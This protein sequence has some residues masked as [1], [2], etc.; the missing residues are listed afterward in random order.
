M[1]EEHDRSLAWRV[2]GPQGSGVDTAARLFGG[3]CVAGG[4]HVFGRREYYSNIM[5][6]HSYYDVRV[7]RRPMSC[8]RNQVEMLVTFDAETLAR[9]SVSTVPG[10]AIIYDEDAADEPLRRITFLDER[11]QEDL[12]AYLAASDLPPTTA[13]ALEDAR[14]RGVETVSVSYDRI[15]D[16]LAQDERYRAKADLTKNTIAV[17]ISAALLGYD[18]RF[19]EVSLATV[20]ADKK[21]V[22]EL[23]VR[24][25]ELA[26][27]YVREELPVQALAH[28]LVA[29]RSTLPPRPGKDGEEMI[30]AGGNEAVALGK[31]AAGMT[32]QTYYPIS[33]ATDESFY[34]EAHANVPQK[35]GSTAAI[36]IV[37][38]EDEISAV[39]MA[40]GA[41]LTGARSATATAGPGFSLMVEGMG[42]AGMN[43]VPL[44]I[45][46]YQRGGP[47]TG[48]PTRTEQS[49]LL[50]AINA[51]HGEFPRL[52]IASGDLTEA[53]YDAARAFDYAERYQTPVIHL[54]DQTIARTTQTVPPFDLSRIQIQRG[55]IY[56]PATGEG[57][58]E[59]GE[60][61]YQRFALTES[62]V[63]PR[64]LVG[65]PG[66]THW[67]TGSE[68][69][70]DGL[71]TED[72]VVRERQMEKRARKLELAAREIPLEQKLQVY[73][74]P[75]AALTMVSWGSNKGAILEALAGL[76]A[77]GIPA[78]L[79]QVHLLWPFPA[80]ELDALLESAG[81]VVVVESNNSGQFAQ[82]LSGQT[83]RYVDHLVAKYNGRPMTCG[84]VSRALREIY[85]GTAER[86]IVL[87]NPYE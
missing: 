36:V 2:G 46:L 69:T 14:R 32:F 38:T 49:D 62:G 76:E 31:M 82:L 50:F 68:H 17:A 39:T 26:Y 64:A 59:A 24:A 9:H 3:A 78:R 63:S 84:E 86:R 65:Q 19:L 37:Q 20:F 35:D 81:T 22:V 79:I 54:L 80:R 44:V 66:G 12:A 13:G 18:P 33:P 40:A 70:E 6:R 83:C 42:W 8:H 21:G 53:F 67:L 58:G 71:V 61:P 55:L 30:L 25:V 4:L 57:D 85:Q 23:N 27:D 77:D 48:L 47:S 45:T 15:I 73:G 34:L 87:R 5:G 16:R 72:P 56:Q 51:G 41:A 74:D 11:A 28:Q 60:E 43:E 10:G 75:D 1:A 7:D 52:V 29:P